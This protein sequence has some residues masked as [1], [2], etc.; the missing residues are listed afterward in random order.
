M[1]KNMEVEI[2][3][4]DS[5][6]RIIIPFDWRKREMGKENKVYIIKEKGYL[7]II[8]MKKINLTKFFDKVDFGM[9]IG[10]WKEFE[11]KI[12]RIK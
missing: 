7:K 12:Y 10:E 3:K 1:V 2:K 6:G 5:Q 11:K 8:P 4:V 9:N